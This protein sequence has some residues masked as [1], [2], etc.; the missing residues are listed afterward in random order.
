[1]PEETQLNDSSVTV[2]ACMK[3]M[4]DT[5][6]LCTEHGF[7]LRKSV[8]DLL[9]LRLNNVFKFF[10]ERKVS[11][12]LNSEPLHALSLLSSQGGIVVVFCLFNSDV[13][14]EVNRSAERTK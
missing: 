6:R 9:R 4:A 2:H 7:C 5:V 1:M 12:E 8:T 10:H 13:N 3:G 11:K 14:R